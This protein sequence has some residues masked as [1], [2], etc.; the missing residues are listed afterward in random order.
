MTTAQTAK[1]SGFAGKEMEGSHMQEE[2][3][4][5][6]NAETWCL[7]ENGRLLSA[8]PRGGGGNAIHDLA[9]GEEKRDQVRIDS[10][11]LHKKRTWKKSESGLEIEEGEKKRGYKALRNG[12][13]PQKEKGFG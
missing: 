2:E 10:R 5:R 13:A 9:V 4:R 11:R 7:E 12:K 6:Q 1:G 3:G 8:I